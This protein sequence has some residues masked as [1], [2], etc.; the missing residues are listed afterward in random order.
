[1]GAKPCD[2]RAR[3]GLL[4]QLD[5]TR[6]SPIRHI[7]GSIDALARSEMRTILFGCIEAEEPLTPPGRLDKRAPDKT[8]GASR[9]A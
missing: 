7:W 6:A 5:R 3:R 2:I 4:R 1:L 9:A 8:Y